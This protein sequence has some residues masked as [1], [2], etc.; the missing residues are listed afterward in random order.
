MTISDAFDIP[1][2]PKLKQMVTNF[3]RFIRDLDEK[4]TFSAISRAKAGEANLVELLAV[5]LGISRSNI[6]AACV[7][8]LPDFRLR[9]VCLRRGPATLK[10]LDMRVKFP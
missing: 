8:A 7:P 4:I 10:P 5:T 1:T 9:I 3:S 2:P 6:E